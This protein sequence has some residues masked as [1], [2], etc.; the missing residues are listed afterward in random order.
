MRKTRIGL[1]S[2]AVVCG[3]V[4]GFAQADSV[5]DVEN[6]RAKERQGRYLNG[7]DREELRRYGS[8][9]DYGWR[10]GPSEDGYYG[11]RYY[12]GASVY[13]GPR[14]YHDPHDY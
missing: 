11:D 7:Q 6:A 14:Y 8:N 10:G 2:A 1:I 13:V 9:D 4:P 3:L 5:S 12:G